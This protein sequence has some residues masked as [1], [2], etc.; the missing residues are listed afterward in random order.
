MN[1]NK[2]ALALYGILLG[3][4]VLVIAIILKPSPPVNIS[5]SRAVLVETQR[6][7]KI[8]LAPSIEGFGRVA[9]KQAW[10]AIAEVSGKVIFRHPQLESGR[11]LPKGLKILEI[12]PLEYQLKL[13]QAQAALHAT[14]AQLTRLEQQQRNLNASLKIESQKLALAEQEYQRKLSLKKRQLVSSSELEAQ[15]QSLL[16][17][18]KLVEDLQSSL[19]LL[20]D[21][22][23]VS[24]AQLNV[25][26]AK[27]KDAQRKLDQTQVFLPF[28]AR[29]AEVSVEENQVVTQGM[30]MLSAHKLGA[31]EIKAEVS[32]SDMRTL[33]TSL[34]Q[35]PREPSLPSIELLNLSAS[36]TLQIANHHYLWPARVTR[37][38]EMVNPNQASIGLY[39][40]VEQ[41]Y[42]QLDL[43]KSPPLTKGMF[44]SATILGQAS[45]QFVV[46]QKA[47]HGDKLYFMSAD[48]TLL[49]KT[50]KTLFRHNDTVAVAL[51][52]E[53]E[54]PNNRSATST[55]VAQSL[56]EGDRL[57]VNDLIPAMPGMSL[58]VGIA[59]ESQSSAKPS[60]VNK[61]DQTIPPQL[62]PSEV[63]PSL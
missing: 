58:R 34:E 30:T 38:A 32:L 53:D 35:Q 36:V 31:A 27:L 39:L 9:P 18:T 60:S 43:L 15:H 4:F 21:D 54:L 59:A 14:Q 10:D 63:E 5:H 57:I 42:H 26:E 23:K 22:R 28:E 48:N 8:S 40:E 29:I 16:V 41:D 13:A 62:S 7:K 52:S 46:P 25:D 6:L 47:L 50:V 17:Q 19:K 56:Q 20:P 2:K 37:V 61:R 33:V 51:A 24:E 11:M 45:M 49:I 1:P 55:L 44:V 3:L 12:D